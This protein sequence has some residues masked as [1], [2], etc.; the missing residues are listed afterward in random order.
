MSY[1]V[2]PI[3]QYRDN[4]SPLKIRHSW[5]GNQSDTLVRL[6]TDHVIC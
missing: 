5:I 1:Q 3:A 2:V 6:S 4:Y